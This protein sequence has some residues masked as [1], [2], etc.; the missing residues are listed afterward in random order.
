[1]DVETSEDA[2]GCVRTNAEEGLQRSLDEE[3]RFSMVLRIRGR[4]RT[5]TR[6]RS[7]K[8]TLK[9]KTYSVNVHVLREAADRSYHFK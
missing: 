8:L 9:M 5:F 3:G 1:V 7:G 2:G 4:I 6:R